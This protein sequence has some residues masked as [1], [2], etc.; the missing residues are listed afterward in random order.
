L[1]AIPFSYVYAKNLFPNP[2]AKILSFIVAFSFWPIYVG[3]FAHPV[4]LVVTLEWV[5]LA[6][7]SFWW[8]NRGGPRESLSLG[9]LSLTAGIGF[10]THLHWPAVAFIALGSVAFIRFKHWGCKPLPWFCLFGPCLLCLIPLVLAT[11]NGDYGSYWQTLWTFKDS[12]PPLEWLLNPI[13]YFGSIFWGGPHPPPTYSPFWG[14]YLNP[15]LGAFTLLGAVSFWSQRKKPECLFI[16][17]SLPIFFLPAFLT[18]ATEFFR[19]VTLLPPLFILASAGILVLFTQPFF[20]K[21]RFLCVSLLTASLVLDAGHLKVYQSSWAQ[22]PEIWKTFGK[23]RSLYLAERILRHQ[24]IKEGSGLIFTDL[25][26]ISCEPSLAVATFSYNAAWNN[27]IKITP[28]WGALLLRQDYETYCKTHYPKAD[29]H[30]L[31]ADSPDSPLLACVIW[32][33]NEGPPFDA[34]NTANMGFRQYSRAEIEWF[35]R[36]YRTHLR[37][38]LASLKPPSTS[39][40]WLQAF[41]WEKRSD[42]EKDDIHYRYFHPSWNAELGLYPSNRN[43]QKL[44]MECLQAAYSWVP[45]PHLHQAWLDEKDA[46]VDPSGPRP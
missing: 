23:S 1:V 16:L 14:G 24:S 31:P 25:N 26:P 41:Y 38:L 42:L 40:P 13:S 19:I 11:Q 5:L 6:I 29:W 32:K 2:F 22:Q 27:C 12:R 36:P 20:Q 10:Y 28:H 15:L 9:I 35:D 8:K 18:R 33:V 30:P 43:N 4:V 21:H 44:R 45:A 37:P 46:I 7:W 34:M 39:E 17:L 3:L